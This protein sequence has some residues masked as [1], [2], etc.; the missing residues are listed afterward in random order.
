L[1]FRAMISSK[2]AGRA[3]GLARHIEDAINA[4]AQ[5]GIRT[6]GEAS[7]RLV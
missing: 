2:V 5:I 1:A 6:I 4:A 3:T 7:L